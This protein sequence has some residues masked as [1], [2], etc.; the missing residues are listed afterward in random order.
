MTSIGKS[1][2]LFHRPRPPTPCH[3]TPAGARAWRRP[4]P[5]APPTLASTPPGR[6]QAPRAT[7]RHPAPQD[8][9]RTGGWGRAACAP[10]GLEGTDSN[11]MR[12]VKE[13]MRA[14]GQSSCNAGGAVEGRRLSGCT[15]WDSEHERE[16]GAHACGRA[17]RCHAKGCGTRAPAGR[18]GETRTQDGHASQ[19]CA[20]CGETSGGAGDGGGVVPPHGSGRRRVGDARGAVRQRTRRRLPGGHGLGQWEGGLQKVSDAGGF[21]RITSLCV[22]AAMI[23]SAP[24]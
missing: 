7:G 4:A 24:R 16:T 23:R 15:R 20:V 22:M 3:S 1:N 5:L 19:P 13:A 12:A 18:A 10:G 9:D 6:A 11:A 2:G 21:S 8:T 14:R 17:R